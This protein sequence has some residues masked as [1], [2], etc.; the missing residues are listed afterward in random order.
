MNLLKRIQFFY[1]QISRRFYDKVCRVKIAAQSV[2]VA[3]ARAILYFQESERVIRE[4]LH[5]DGS[6]ESKPVLGSPQGFNTPG[7][8][9]SQLISDR[10]RNY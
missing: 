3:H 7:S 6:S 1:K 4:L 9:Y 2:L 8:I 5:L 10:N